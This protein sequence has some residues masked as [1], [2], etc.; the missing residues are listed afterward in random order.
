VTT[1]ISNPTLHY[2]LY[3]ILYE[4]EP[5]TRFVEVDNQFGIQH[6][7]VWGPVGLLVPTQKVEPGHHEPPL[8]LDH[9]LLYLVEGLPVVPVDVVL[10]DQFG[11]EPDATVYEPVLLANP[12]RKTHGDEVTE[13]VYPDDHLLFYNI[14]I[15]DAPFQTQVQVNNQFGDQTLDLTDPALLAVPS[16]KTELELPP[17]DHFKCYEAEGMLADETVLLEDQFDTFEAAYVEFAWFFSNPVEKLHDEMVTPILNQDHHLTIY[18]ILCEGTFGHYSAV[19]VYNQFGIH[20]LD[21]EAPVYLAVP[22][23]KLDPGP[24]GPPVGLDHFL[25]YP[26]GIG[27]PPIEVVVSLNDQFHEEPEVWVLEPV[28]FGSPVQKTHGDTVTPI[29][30]PEAHLVFYAISGGTFDGSVVAENQ[31]SLGPQEL[32]V[33]N[34]VFLAVPSLKLRYYPFYVDE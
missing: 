4:E 8:R 24:H 1:P 28:Y 27:G 10:N 9:F 23:Q 7:E 26:V 19:D 2:T 29:E 22:T 18:N 31:F 33:Y 11:G 30:H 16:T 3:D 32:D 6:L 15:E 14:D 34:P 13:I 25:L 21:V 17:L 12:V 20:Y 5:Q